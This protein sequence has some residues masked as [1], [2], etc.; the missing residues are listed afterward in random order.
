MALTLVS[1]LLMLILELL[2]LNSPGLLSSTL[3]GVDIAKEWQLVGENSL[4]STEKL[5]T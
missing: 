5:E 1:L 4:T 3:L 2:N